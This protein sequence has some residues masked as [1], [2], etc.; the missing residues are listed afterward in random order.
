MATAY[1]DIGAPGHTA[2]GAEEKHLEDE[3][4]NATY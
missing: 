1:G 2:G 4:N 3:F